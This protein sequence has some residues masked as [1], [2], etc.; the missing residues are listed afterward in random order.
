[1][2]LV[3]YIKPLQIGIK[4]C[5]SC[6]VIKDVKYFYNDRTNKDGKASRCKDCCPTI[7]KMAAFSVYNSSKGDIKLHA[8]KAVRAARTLRLLTTQ[9]CILCQKTPSVIAHHFDY[10]LPLMI[11]WLCSTCHGKVHNFMH[12]IERFYE[13]NYAFNLWR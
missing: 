11:F 8:H 13:S 5:P 10:N 9:P 4:L 7:S 12:N 6:K 1:M 3:K 2:E